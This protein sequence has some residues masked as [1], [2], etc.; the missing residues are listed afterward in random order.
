MVIVQDE[1]GESLDYILAPDISV[2]V[3]DF[4]DDSQDD[5]ADDTLD[6]DQEEVPEPFD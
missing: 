5:V 2:E 6:Q 3:T 1:S 4:T